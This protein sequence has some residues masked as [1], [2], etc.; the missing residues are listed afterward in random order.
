MA[1]ARLSTSAVPFLDNFGHNAIGQQALLEIYVVLVFKRFF[2]FCSTNVDLVE[3]LIL[4]RVYLVLVL[5][6]VKYY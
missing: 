4:L 1:L 2:L 3:V 6:T 5:R